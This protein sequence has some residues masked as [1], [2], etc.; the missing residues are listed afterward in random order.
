MTVASPSLRTTR[1]SH[2]AVNTGTGQSTVTLCGW[3]GKPPGV[4]VCRRQTSLARC[5]PR[6]QRSTLACPSPTVIRDDWTI[7]LAS[8][9]KAYQNSRSRR[10]KKTSLWLAMISEYQ[11]TPRRMKIKQRR[12]STSSISPAN[13]A[14]QCHVAVI[15][16]TD[17]LFCAKI[18]N[19][20][21]WCLSTVST[22]QCGIWQVSKH[23]Y[24]AEITEWIAL[25]NWTIPSAKLQWNLLATPHITYL[26]KNLLPCKLYR[27][28]WN[29]GIFKGFLA[30]R[31]ATAMATIYLHESG[32]VFLAWKHRF[33]MRRV[34]NFGK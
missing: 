21:Y 10:Q 34:Y 30:C 31:L 32:H 11:Q 16:F 1:L 23:I 28:Q 18:L 27:L 25:T 19:T 12:S 5:L 14:R 3:E 9:D 7:L 33:L 17:K 24:T 6:N 26:Q 4:Q 29:N 15:Y 8:Q 22:L 2:Q 13:T 20:Q